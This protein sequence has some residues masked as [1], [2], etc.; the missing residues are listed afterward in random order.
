MLI[1]LE[2]EIAGIEN[3]N[4]SNRQVT[5]KW[6]VHDMP[7][8]IIYKSLIINLCRGDICVSQCV[9]AST[10]F[11]IYQNAPPHVTGYFY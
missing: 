2:L 6:E 11:I 10:V 4:R 7:C 5:D 8:F 9:S 3:Y 1:L